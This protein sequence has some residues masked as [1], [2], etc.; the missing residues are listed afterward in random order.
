LRTLLFWKGDIWGEYSYIGLEDTLQATGF[1]MFANYEQTVFY[2]RYYNNKHFN[3]DKTLYS[4]FPVYFVNS[5]QTEK[6]FLGKDS[7]VYGIQEAVEKEAYDWYK[8]IESAGF[9]FCGNGCWGMIVRPGEFVVVLM[10]KYMGSYE[11]EMRVRFSVGENIYVSKPFLGN[12]SRNQFLI[13][14]SS[15]AHSVIKSNNDVPPFW[16]FY[17]AN[18]KEKQWAVKTF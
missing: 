17:G 10:R 1:E 5:T 7:Y 18:V 8:P 4:Y 15:Y 13:S 3:N 11:T 14:D 2:N 16:L 9:D 6:I 12:I